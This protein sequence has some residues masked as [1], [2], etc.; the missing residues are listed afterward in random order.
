MLLVAAGIAAGVVVELLGAPRGSGLLAAVV[1][2]GMWSLGER[3]LAREARD[4]AELTAWGRAHRRR[5]VADPAPPCKASFLTEERVHFRNALEGEGMYL[6]TYIRD[7]GYDEA[8]SSAEYTIAITAASLGGVDPFMLRTRAR[9]PVGRPFDA[10]TA[11]TSGRRTQPL[12]EASLQERFQLMTS[13]DHDVAALARLFSPERQAALAALD[14]NS[15][16]H[17]VEFTGTALL[18]ASE[19]R[20]RPDVVEELDLESRAVLTV[21]VG[22]EFRWPPVRR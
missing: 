18:A 5:F 8:H 11:A 3:V 4:A 9:G 21:F 15:F 12:D 20:L 14:R 17:L 7:T 10:I 2:I 6:G 16:L 19:R 1:V 22:D 13:H